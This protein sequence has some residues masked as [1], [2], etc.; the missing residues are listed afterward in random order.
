LIV[1]DFSGGMHLADPLSDDRVR[2]RG[3]IVIH[4]L[5]YAL[6][7]LRRSPLFA[8][9]AIV[10]LAIGIAVNTIVFTLLNSLALRP[11]P[12]RGADRVVRLYPVDSRGHRQNLFSYPDYVDYRKAASV[13]DDL[14]AYIPASVT[15]QL[16]GEAED[17]IAYVVAPNYFTLLGIDPSIGRVFVASDER[18]ADPAIAIISH[19]LWRRRFGSDPA[20]VGS[21]IVINH[22]S[23]TIVG[24]GPSRFSGTEPLSPDVWVT[25]SV[26]RRVL[27]PDDLRNDR[28]AEWLLVVGRL[29]SDVSHSV[30]ANALSSTARQLATAF[31][32][33]N[34]PSA[35]TV[36]PGTFFTL[37]PGIWPVI[38][39][40][41]SIVGLVLAIACANVG[42]LVLARTT[43]R[44]REI[45]VRL[46]IGATRWR[47]VRQ[48]M[49]ESIIISL[50]A[51]ALGLLVATWTLE[52]LYPLGLS[53]VPTEWGAVV[54]DLSPDLRVFAYTFCLALA[55]GVLL[56]LA[57][58]LQSSSP[59][60]AA[61][62]HDDGAMI[63]LRLRPG[64]LRS[65][66]VILQVA[67]CMVL[68][69]GAGLLTRGLQHMR[70]LDVGFRTADVLF[71]EYDLRRQGYTVE[72]AREFN[73]RLAE[74]AASAGRGPAAL[75]SHVPLHGG[76]RRTGVW[77]EGHAEQVMCTTTS[78]SR[79]YFE[80]LDISIT[81]G[82]SFSDAEDRDG[83][84]VVIIS[85][86]LATR[87]WPGVDPIGR[88]VDVNPMAVPLTVVGIV[89]DTSSATIWRDK[90]MSL[91]VPQG[92][93][94][95]RDLQVIVRSG[96]GASALA[97][98][99][100]QQ[101]SALD[102][103]VHFTVAPLESLL[104]LWI[105]PSRVAAITAAILGF[106]A[107]ALASLGLYAV[108][109]YDVTH[110]TREI[111]VRLALG[112][113]G[114]DVVRL[115]LVDGARLVAIG[116]ACGLAGAAILGRLL[117]GFLFD[118][119]AVDPLTFVLIPGFLIVVAI[120]ACYVPARQA[121]RIEPLDALRAR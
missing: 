88:K 35:V 5:R 54:L 104:R 87:F 98:L 81:R 46:A 57:P 10:T 83:S 3:T 73:R 58:A 76:V 4:D 15:A 113:S 101:A 55:A 42:N 37:D 91:Y 11:M 2:K 43:G 65:A 110:R 7:N 33:R 95:Q 116:L 60:V 103:G 21:T 26:Q 79:T 100:R 32:G 1:D 6:R 84:P 62:L 115:I 63:G 41:L 8:L 25:P 77:P 30:A 40:V 85:E 23:F 16:G 14:T 12:V 36:V 105:L 13:F 97:S 38:I 39:L 112:A 59:A 82:R 29:K 111:G 27:P 94:D 75:T 119:N 56:G 47:V 19:S 118:V 120:A 44:Q 28:S 49:A 102:P 52:L 72:R 69:I 61:S 90:E 53:Y 9:S 66:L 89:R 64:R 114:G 70:S 71:T 68:L 80:T 99:L 96:D 45:A 121:S 67:V 117:R 86:G 18:A 48:L 24:V 17:L 51:G 107:L 92:L 106:L 74:T 50:A 20:V 93:G 31:P 109:A 78:V 22:R 34:R 108:I